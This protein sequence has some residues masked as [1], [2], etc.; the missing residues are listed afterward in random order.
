MHCAF[1]DM[2]PMRIIDKPYGE[3]DIKNIEYD[4]K[5][6]C[7]EGGH[8]QGGKQRHDADGERGEK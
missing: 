2:E 8:E 5:Q 6:Q 4:G 7:D 3:I 1:D